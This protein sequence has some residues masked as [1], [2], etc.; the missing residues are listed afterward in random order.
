[1]EA[2]PERTETIAAPV[3][4][5]GSAGLLTIS[6]PSVVAL[7]ALLTLLFVGLALLFW[8]GRVRVY[9]QGRGVVWLS[10]PA[11]VLRSPFAGRVL[12]VE[13]AVGDRGRAG[14][15]LLRLDARRSEV[16]HLDCSQELAIDTRDL[17]DLERRL[18]EWQD[19]ARSARE[20]S[21]ALMLIAQV[22]AQRDRVKDEARRCHEL[23]YAMAQSQIAFPVDATVERLEVGV[24]AEVHEGDELG[25]L[26]PLR[27]RLVGYLAL[28]DQYGAELSVGRPVRL[29]FDALPFDE[30]GVGHAVVTRVLDALPSGVK[31]D[32]GSGS[33]IFAE[34]AIDGMPRGRGQ[35]R[36]GMMF[37]GDM[38]AR[39]GRVLDLLFH[40]PVGVA[41]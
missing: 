38:F 5:E 8:F 2:Q 41:H 16:A 3:T 23:E 36:V 4:T 33:G 27:A 12:A 37:T 18:R 19:T 24:G 1:M 28:P 29:R 22:G 31:L 7:F 34:L 10:E 26:V 6:P 15:I 17:H 35:A 11:I 25:T 9:A 13:R 14:S 30:A 21:V 40:R 20:S 39:E 32:T